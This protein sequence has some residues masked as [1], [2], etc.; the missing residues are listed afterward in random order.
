MSSVRCPVCGKSFHPDHTPAM[1]FCSRR[2]RDIDL[3]RWLQEEY[4]LPQEGEPEAEEPEPPAAGP[5]D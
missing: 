2:C 3:K 4:G 5:E 1:P